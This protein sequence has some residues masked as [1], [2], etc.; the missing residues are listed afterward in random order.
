MP[1]SESSES[2]TVRRSGDVGDVEAKLDH[3]D[4]RLAVRSWTYAPRVGPGG[5]DRARVRD[6]LSD[7]RVVDRTGLVVHERV[8][9]LEVKERPREASLTEQ[10]GEPVGEPLVA[11]KPPEIRGE[12]RQLVLRGDRARHL[13]PAG[14]RQ[15]VQVQADRDGRLSPPRRPV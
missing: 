8:D 13:V 2:H 14:A 3:A 12:Q 6:E 5:D 4:G 15:P 10:H 1:R 7:Q 11:A 9:P